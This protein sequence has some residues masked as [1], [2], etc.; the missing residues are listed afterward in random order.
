MQIYPTTQNPLFIGLFFIIEVTIVV[1]V[2]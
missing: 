2:D 1:N